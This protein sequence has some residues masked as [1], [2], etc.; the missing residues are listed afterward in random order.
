MDLESRQAEIA[1]IRTEALDARRNKDWRAGGGIVLAKG[2]TPWQGLQQKLRA[3][4]TPGAIWF[5]DDPGDIRPY[6]AASAY[7]ATN[8]HDARLY[9]KPVSRVVLPTGVSVS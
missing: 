7:M 5:V 3:Q 1:T 2:A 6:V 8:T 4:M 9:P